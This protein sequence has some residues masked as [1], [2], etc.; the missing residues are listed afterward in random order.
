MKK[1]S[2]LLASFV[3]MSAGLVFLSQ[4]DGGW[5][6]SWQAPAPVKQPRINLFKN[7]SDIRRFLQQPQAYPEKSILVSGLGSGNSDLTTRRVWATAVNDSL[8]ARDFAEAGFWSIDLQNASSMPW[9]GVTV[10][11]V[12]DVTTVQGRIQVGIRVFKNRG[13]FTGRYVWQSA[14]GRYTVQTNPFVMEPG[15]KYE[16][17]AYFGC[18]PENQQASAGIGKVVEIKW[19]I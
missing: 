17:T 13:N 15:Q 16:A 5:A 2:L 18:Y 1:L 10:S 14:P 19:G 3:V 8:E 9:T 6:A 11:A 12:F 4:V 7:V